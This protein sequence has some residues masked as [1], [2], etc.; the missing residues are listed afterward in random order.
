MA[1]GQHS[2][3]R[4]Y[5]PPGQLGIVF[6]VLITELFIWA[7]IIQMIV[8][9]YCA[10]REIPIVYLEYAD[11]REHGILYRCS[12]FFCFV[13]DSFVQ[14]KAYKS[15]THRS[16]SHLLLAYHFAYEFYHHHRHRHYHCR[17]GCHRSGRRLRRRTNHVV[18]V[19][20][21]R[22]G[23]LRKNHALSI[24]CLIW[25]CVWLAGEQWTHTTICTRSM[26]IR[27]W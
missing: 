13:F 2:T 12:V 15:D 16:S 27:G 1:F 7:N 22:F 21:I 26:F 18:F 6:N 25:R 8:R 24:N 17:R 23:P 10:E 19:C 9:I 5:R 20:F 14:S 11:G 4:T 3:N